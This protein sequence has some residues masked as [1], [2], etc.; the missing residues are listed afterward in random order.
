LQLQY[1]AIGESGG[2]AFELE[3]VFFKGKVQK[4]PQIPFA[5]LQQLPLGQVSAGTFP[6]QF[7]V[8]RAP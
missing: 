4:K 1:V 3:P 2:L 7:N 6:P 8:Y 5:I